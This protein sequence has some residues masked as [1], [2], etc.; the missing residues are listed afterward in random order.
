MG[1]SR[2]GKKPRR[3]HPLA[4]ISAATKLFLEKNKYDCYQEA[5]LYIELIRKQKSIASFVLSIINRCIHI[6]HVLE[7]WKTIANVMIFKDLGV[8]KIHRLQVIHI[9]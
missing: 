1:K 2:L 8:Y 5:Y 7:R 3:H 6:G 4:A 9:Y